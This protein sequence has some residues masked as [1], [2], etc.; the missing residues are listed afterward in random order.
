MKY[1]RRHAVASLAAL[2]TVALVGCA[3]KLPETVK[4]GVVVAQSGSA[5]ARGMDLL[6]G[7]QLA[8]EEL[9]KMPF[10]VAGKPVQI[11]IVAFD[12]KG[13]L[14]PAGEGARQLIDSGAIAILG[15][16]NTPQ[17]TKAVPAV[18]EAGVA[19]LF[20]M[21][22]VN[23]LALG[24]G[25]AF[26]LVA[27]DDLQARAAAGFVL[28]NFKGQR[29]V[30]IHEA[31]DYG[32]GLHTTF[33]DAIGKAGGKVGSTFALDAKAEV[34]AEIA[35]KIK[36]E[37]AEVVM[38]FSREPHL[39]SLYKA[40]QDVGHTNVSVVGANPIR[41][42]GAATLPS[43]VKAVYA[44]ATAIDAKEFLN[45]PKFVAAFEGKFKEPPSW[46]AH[47]FYDAVYAL[48]SG[49]RSIESVERAKLIAYLKTREPNTQVNEQMRWESSG[50]LKYASVAIYN[51][52]RGA[53]Q[54]KMRSSQ[55]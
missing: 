7:A 38:L 24:K 19:H 39:K 14:E 30:S 10:K 4:I 37:N 47:Y 34:S 23:T 2:T 42:K 49:I 1:T 9:N 40:L 16:M 5:G 51:L 43:P 53:W 3:E 21:T 20:T 27:N 25:N 28:D 35:G 13:E 54:L 17:G 33:V 41:T 26:R 32:K 45:G 55:W 6:R 15:P 12:D 36:A 11:E 44:T 52:D 22:S 46:G 29:I 18:A 8:A 50:E 31:T 48:A